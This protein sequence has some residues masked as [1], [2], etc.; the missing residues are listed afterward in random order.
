MVSETALSSMT[1]EEP[2]RE[3][4]HEWYLRETSEGVEVE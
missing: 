1:R 2:W 4:P 3:E